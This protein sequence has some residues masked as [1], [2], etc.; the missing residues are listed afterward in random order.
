MAPWLRSLCICALLFVQAPGWA[1]ASADPAE[2]VRAQIVEAEALASRD[3]AAAASMAKDAATRAH[4]L[5]DRGLE[6]YARLTWADALLKA[7]RL[8]EGGALLGEL[9]QAIGVGTDPAT[10]ARVVVLRARWLRDLNRI[11]EAESAFVRATKLAEGSGD[12]GLLAIVL[13]SHAAMLWRQGHPDEA[14]RRLERALAINQRLE[15]EGEA[16]KN[17]SYLSLIAR[18]RG[19]Y[20]LSLKLNR[21]ILE[22]SMRRDDARGIGVAAN[23]IGLLLVHQDE[24]RAS[25]DSF[26]QAAEAYHRVGDPSGEGPA[27]ANVGT[28]LVKLGELEAARAPLEQALA[29]SRD[30]DDPTAEV[31]A[32]SGLAELAL[33]RQDMVEAER[34]SLASLAASKRQPAASPSVSA[35]GVLASVRRSQ[36]RFGEAV[37]LGREA[38]VQARRQ[39]RL[40]DLRDTLLSLAADLSATGQ[41]DEA[42]RAQLEATEVIS[43]MRD[44][45]VR[46]EAARIE[47]EF[48]ARR[49]E[50]E[51]LVQR[52]RISALERQAEQQRSIRYLL[53][54]A[55]GTFVLLVAALASRMLLKRRAERQ[56]IAHNREIERA[57]LELAEAADTDVLTKARNRRYFHLQLLP[58]LQQRLDSAQAFSLILIDADHFKAI[59]DKHG[60]DVGDRALIAIANAWRAALGPDDC[61]VRWGGE[62]F[63]VVSSEDARAADAL[64]QR[65]LAA[66][67]AS[68]IDALPGLRLTVSVGSVSAPW[69]G[70]DV[71]TLLQVADRAM[72][73][74]KREGRD[75]AIAVQHDGALK[76]TGDVIPEELSELRGV[77]LRRSR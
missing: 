70:A 20:D 57:N 35:L 29:L 39:G 36:G 17:L 37:E 56:L 69:P 25:L 65:G 11:D 22:I 66:T 71:P 5:G 21:D 34:E 58:M 47:S 24:M 48:A 9:E 12:E 3:L 18:D 7:R 40:R 61:L 77:V 59:N 28:T 41:H 13:N 16:L 54:L 51:L 46:R 26:R 23:T 64:V 53:A 62:E 49:R 76:L 27:L 30:T 67:R 6:I 75:R 42:Y 60:H 45:E 55:L 31:I 4:A 74:A 10:E 38:L 15:R 33:R 19:D 72:L 73:M 14:T 1:T 50:H 68:T 52:E 32:R 43:R 2:T 63:L 44:A 8:E